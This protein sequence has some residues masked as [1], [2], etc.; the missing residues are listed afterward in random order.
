MLQ[1]ASRTPIALDGTLSGQRLELKFTER[2]TRRT[3]GGTPV[4]D[5]GDDGSLRGSF[6]SDAAQS[7]GASQATR[8]SAATAVD[9]VSLTTD[10]RSS[11]ASL[12][13]RLSPS[14]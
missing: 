5:V 2:D 4:M 11:A 10:H 8:V 12:S 1:A 6:S 3:S 9:R 13:S 14:F 7:R